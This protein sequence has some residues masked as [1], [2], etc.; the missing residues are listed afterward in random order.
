MP[1]GAS[2]STAQLT[3]RPTYQLA[4]PPIC[5]R[6]SVSQTLT[7]PN[8]ELTARVSLGKRRTD[9][10]GIVSVSSLAAVKGAWLVRASLAPPSLLGPHFR[11]ALASSLGAN[12]AGPAYACRY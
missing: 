11:H 7:F 3:L 12:F 6:L 4:P 9:Y 10:S 1:R 8:L 5:L 2:A